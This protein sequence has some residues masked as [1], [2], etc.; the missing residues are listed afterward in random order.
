MAEKNMVSQRLFKHTTMERKVRK[1]QFVPSTA[2][3]GNN[4][5]SKIILTSLIR[6]TALGDAWRSPALVV[7]CLHPLSA[8]D[9]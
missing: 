3:K 5:A 1:K 8:R 6:T 4:L 7:F 2:A 9:F